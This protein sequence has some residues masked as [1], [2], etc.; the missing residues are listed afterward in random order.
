M[1]KKTTFIASCFAFISTIGINAQQIFTNGPISTGANSSATPPVVAPTGYTWSE[2]QTPNTSL[3]GGGQYNNALTVNNSLADDFVVPVG[4]TWSLTT[5]EFFGYQTGYAGTTT[6]IDAMRVRI[7]NGDP[8]LATSTVVF[9]D[10]TTNV[11]NSVSSGDS[12]VYRIST[13]TPD[14]ARKIW[15]FTGN[16]ATTLTAGT[17]WVEVQ[18]HATNDGNIF[19][20]PV[21]ILNTLSDPTWNS[22]QRIGAAWS[23]LI[24]GGSTFPRALPFNLNGTLLSSDTFELASAVS[25]FPNPATSTVTITDDLKSVNAYIEVYDIMGRSVKAVNCSLDT[26]FS[27]DVTNLL[28]GNYI[29]KLTTENGTI[30]KKFVKI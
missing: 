30:T 29:I 15:K 9:G 25:I 21:T 8:S 3:G 26:S 28:S 10:M 27:L 14:I 6:P 19:F 17:Y 7:W 12:F 5:A 11:L 13:G 18:V 23:N 2:L 16:I 22:K 24:D 20:P 1:N 4:Q